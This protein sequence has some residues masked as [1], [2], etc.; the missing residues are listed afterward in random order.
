MSSSNSNKHL[1][2]E[3]R[4][5][6]EKGIRSGATKA[7]IASTIG[8]DKSTICKEISAHRQRT[9]T[10]NL[11]LECAAY[12]KCKHNRNCST[13]CPDF[14]QFKCKKRDRSPGACN[15]CEKIK[16]CHF[17]HFFY[18]P[19]LAQKKH[20]EVLSTSREGINISEKELRF[21]GEIIT[22]L[23]KK[24]QSPYTILQNHPEITI[25]VKTLYTYIEDGTFRN[26][27]FD[28]SGIDLRRFPGRKPTTRKDKNVYK[29]R[30]ERKYLENRLY[31]NF[32]AYIEENPNTNVV[33]MDTVY[34]DVNGPFMQTFKFKAYSFM[35]IIYHESKT[36]QAMYDGILLLESILGEELFNRE[37]EAIVTD[38]GSEFTMADAIETRADGTRRTRIFYC[39]AMRS[40]QKG[41]LENNHEEIR[42]IC[43]KGTDLYRLGLTDQ[44]K[45]NLIS[46]HINSF[47]KE[48][49]KGK[50]PFRFLDF[51]NPELA[52][53]FKAFGI[54][55]IEPDEVILKPYLLK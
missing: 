18:K 32:L 29:E 51:L 43:P 25:S 15:G 8:K 4:T 10:C 6:I 21:I 26:A 5:I 16:S 12:K 17:D 36:A 22:P 41:S 42:Y 14:V 34:N 53:R 3:E 31:S 24:G 45:A 46:S 30:K 19:D 54:V 27:G 50:S 33:E 47:S 2:F 11:P 49:L 48:N 13:S 39:D 40:N 52:N 37:V 23:I 44:T 28:L 38:R 7:A 55:E 9:K 1:T 20:K 35:V